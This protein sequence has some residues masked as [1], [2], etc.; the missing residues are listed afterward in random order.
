MSRAAPRPA[1]RPD[2]RP[3]LC[4]GSMESVSFVVSRAHSRFRY[5]RQAK[6]RGSPK[7][8]MIP[9]RPQP[10]RAREGWGQ[11]GEPFGGEAVPTPAPRS[12]RPR[13]NSFRDHRPPV[14]ARM[15]QDCVARRW[16]RFGAQDRGAGRAYDLFVYCQPVPWH[17]SH[18]RSFPSSDALHSEGGG[19]HL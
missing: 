7:S 19:R 2:G 4:S 16:S 17:K 11:H 9:V 1:G 5:R 6:L 15:T 3:R 13:R 14:G 12:N 18:G 10:P 8:I